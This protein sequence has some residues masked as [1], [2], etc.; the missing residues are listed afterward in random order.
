MP[1]EKNCEVDEDNRIIICNFIEKSFSKKMS[2]FH[3]EIIA[4]YCIKLLH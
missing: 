4:N 3:K 1:V 2:K